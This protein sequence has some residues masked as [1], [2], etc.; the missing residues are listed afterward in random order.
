[1]RRIA[2]IAAILFAASPVSAHEVDIRMHDR[3]EGQVKDMQATL[4]RLQNAI[5]GGNTQQRFD[6]IASEL[7]RLTGEIEQLGFQLR[8]FQQDAKRKLEDLEYRVIELEGGDPTSL[9]E[10][11]TDDGLRQQNSL[12]NDQQASVKTLGAISSGGG[13]AGPEQAAYDAGV[14]AAQGGRTAEARNLL[15]GFIT[16]YPDSA[17]TGDAYFWLG[18][19]FYLEGDYRSAASRFLD[20]ATL[21]PN[22]SRA[23]ESLLKLGMSLSVL[24]E[25]DVACSTFREVSQRYPG[26]G[27]IIRKAGVESQ[28]AGCR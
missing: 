16:S 25:T 28:R 13:A 10:N 14:Q 21:Y 26:S 12:S 15:N 6:G 17:L 5:G 22:A 7:S 2:L 11:N 8:T 1:M 4:Q 23:S 27:E 24:G 20:A 18:E 19:S 3:L 9:Y